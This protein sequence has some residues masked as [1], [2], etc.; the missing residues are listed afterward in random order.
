MTDRELLV[1]LY[2][3]AIAAVDAESA[4]R[5]SLEQDDPGPGPFLLLGAGKAACAMARG[6][7][8]VLG[9]R[10]GGGAVTTKH[11]HALSLDG[12]EVREAGHP[13]PDECSVAAAEGALE[14]VRA[15]DASEPLLVLLSGGAS[16]L[17]T[18]PASGLTL[19]DKRRTSDLL[20]RAGAG[21][22][23]L[24]TVRKHLSRIKGG[25]LLRAAS[26]ARILTL[27]LSDVAD[28]TPDLIGSGPSV[29]DPSTYTEALALLRASGVEREVPVSVRAHLEAGTTGA[30]PE[31]VKPG[32][33]LLER[34]EYRLVASLGDALEAAAASAEE[35]GLRVRRLG[36]MLYGESRELARAM[37]R[38]AREALDEGWE[39][40][41][42]GGEPTVRVRGDGRGG[43]AQELALAFALEL[44]GMCGVTALFAGTDG[45]DGPTDAAGGLVDEGTLSRA[46]ALG[47]DIRAY[48][49]R[50][51]AYP[52]LERTGDL[53]VT[54]PT[55]TNVTDLAL[56]RIRC[57]DSGAMR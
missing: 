37:G 53:F 16:A 24:N 2:R 1:D 12:L 25:G 18:A 26:S 29:A 56:V 51:D 55:H 42:G 28:G 33:P 15:C 40:L 48:L 7:Q 21:I 9:G 10:I 57:R 47:L 45:T 41:V 44:R 52:L 8:S 49:E 4:V 34:V 13:L 54:G 6:A 17:W 36:P 35:Q 19:E 20:L 43:R 32:D 38:K 46:E 39:L 30:R 22:R 50:N 31:T 3:R 5:R 27:A 23:T 11:G 14:R